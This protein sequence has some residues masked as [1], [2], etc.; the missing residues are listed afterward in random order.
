MA[1]DTSPSSQPR[2]AEK[3]TTQTSDGVDEPKTRLT[4]TRR[5]FA[6]ARAARQTSNTTVRKA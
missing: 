1:V 6:S 5:V 3:R 2:I 4:L